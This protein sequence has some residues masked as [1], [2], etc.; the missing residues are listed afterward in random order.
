MAFVFSRR[1]VLTQLAAIPI[2]AGFARNLLAQSADAA[3]RKNL[4]I[5]MANNG[6]KRAAFWPAV[7]PATS[8][9]AA[10]LPPTSLTTTPILNTLFTS[11]GVTDNGLKANTNILRGLTVVNMSPIGFVDA[12]DVGF[13][14]MFTGASLV[15]VGGAPYGGAISIDQML[16]NYWSQPSLTTAV[17]ASSLQPFPKKGFNNRASFSY[18]KVGTLHVPFIDPYT[19]FLS[20]FGRFVPGAGAGSAA[21]GS[22]ADSTQRLATRQSVLNTVVGDLKE[23]QGRLG[24]DDGRKLDLHLSAIADVEAQLQRLLNMY[25]NAAA[26]TNPPMGTLPW[27]G[28]AVSANG[29]PSFEVSDETYNDQQIQFMASLISAAIRCRLTRVASLQFGY[30]GGQWAFGW[31]NPT[32]TLNPA[33]RPI[34]YNLTNNVPQVDNVD[35]MS[36]PP[37]AQYVTWINQYYANTVRKVATDL[38]AMPDGAGTMLDNTLI[39]WTNELGRADHQLTDIPVVF[40]GLVKNGISAGGRLIAFGPGGEIDHRVMGYHALKALGYDFSRPDAAIWN[41]PNLAFPGF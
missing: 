3:P 25:T 28:P 18:E 35:D 38:L 40:M 36:N 6:T 19:A 17:Y 21:A 7:M 31:L 24:P 37:T 10:P 41:V 2:T 15:G 23:L 33:A 8:P 9:G 16:A 27:F 11:D 12:H 29:P 4:I 13:A 30:G 14:R 22:Q 1:S 34:N 32:N 5:F 26:C 20:F 39:I